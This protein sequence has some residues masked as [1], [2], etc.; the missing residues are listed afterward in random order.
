MRMIFK[1]NGEL[2]LQ[3]EKKSKLK[4]KK[5][6]RM[7]I[8]LS[9]KRELHGYLNIGPDAFI[10]WFYFRLNTN[11]SIRK[12]GFT[13]ELDLLKLINLSIFTIDKDEPN[14]FI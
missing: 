2:I 14:L 9:S 5:E 6:A 13:I 4:V 3:V 1:K 8:K 10:N 7:K 12:F 11:K